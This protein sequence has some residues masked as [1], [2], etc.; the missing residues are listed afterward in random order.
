MT[1]GRLPDPPSGNRF[2]DRVVV[3]TGG[4]AGIGEATALRFA[5]E[6]AAV[7]VVD[8]LADRAEAVT[9]AINAAG[10]SATACPADV[11][12]AQGWAGIATVVREHHG[13]IDV[14]HNN[15]YTVDVRPADEMPEESWDRQ[16]AVDLSAVYHSVR[17]FMPGLRESKGC[18]VNTSSVHALMGFPGHAAY[19]A[20][21]GGMIAL[22]RQ[23]AV[24]YG[25]DVRVNAVLPGCVLTHA[26]DGVDQAGFDANLARTTAGRIGDPAEVA[27]AVTFLASSDASYI[28]GTS[29]VVDGGM[30]ALGVR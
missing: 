8:L 30:T 7:V 11:G 21:K 14:V 24:D 16:L 13:R 22:S 10:G 1:E 26:W 28:T 6:G 23:L 9:T 12:T 20:A 5:A 15:A 29:L 17:A 3:V 2:R 18:M 25:P 19:A 4:G 27:A